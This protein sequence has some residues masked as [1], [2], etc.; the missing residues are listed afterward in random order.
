MTIITI[1]STNS[2]ITR[3]NSYLTNNI[4]WKDII[5]VMDQDT[6]YLIRVIYVL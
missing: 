5:K 3:T 2:N 6:K 4:S 1:E